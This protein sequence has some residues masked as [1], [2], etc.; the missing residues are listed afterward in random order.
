MGQ[1]KESIEFLEQ[2]EAEASAKPFEKVSEK[3][4]A[5][6]KKLDS[7][8]IGSDVHGNSRKIPAKDL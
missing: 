1:I 6:T 3:S 7:C 4:I 5:G 2:Q 8:L